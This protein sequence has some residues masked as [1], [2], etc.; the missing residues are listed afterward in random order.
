MITGLGDGGAEAVLV[1]LILMSRE[2]SH[3]VLSLKDE[4]KYYKTLIDH[5]TRV[6]CLHLGRLPH[7]I[8]FFRAIYSAIFIFRPSVIQTWMYHA[9]LLGG[10]LGR[11]SGNIPIVWGIHN[12]QTRK[13]NN[14]FMTFFLIKLCSLLART[15]PSKIVSCSIVA[16]AAHT[17]IGYPSA[18]MI[19]IPNGIP[20]DKFHPSYRLRSETRS[21]FKVDDNDILIGMVARYG[22]QKDHLTLLKAIRLMLDCGLNA[23]FLLVGHGMDSTCPLIAVAERLK[24]SDCLIFS[25]PS[26][27]IPAIMNALDIHVL[28]SSSSEAY[29][30]VL[31]EAMACGTICVATD[32]GDSASIIGSTGIVVKPSDPYCLAEAIMELIPVCK[33]SK[34]KSSIANEARQ[35]FSADLMRDSYLKLW[36]SLCR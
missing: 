15:V 1:R 32:V 24:I 3:M 22:R 19:Y 5:G 28:S 4:G 10:I 33:D 2:H 13:K 25:G 20:L 29:P 21:Q 27:N 6:E 23:K 18:K 34:L 11:I 12:S 30:N 8:T 31:C 26:N 14:T 36:S 9:D 35:R 16:I 17:S 7:V